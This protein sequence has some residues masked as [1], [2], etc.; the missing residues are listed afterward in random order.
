LIISRDIILIGIK[1]KLSKSLDWFQKKTKA[2]HAFQV[3]MDLDYIEADCFAVK[4]P[5][6]ISVM[7]LLMVLV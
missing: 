7:N 4:T 2:E 5:V 3:C 1:Q 6:K